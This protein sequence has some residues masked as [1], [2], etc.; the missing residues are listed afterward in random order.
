MTTPEP[1]D[2]ALPDGP[3][4]IVFHFRLPFAVPVDPDHA[5]AFVGKGYANASDAA[6]YPG[7]PFVRLQFTHVELDI[8]AAAPLIRPGFE[9]GLTVVLGHQGGETS[10]MP[11]LT[12]YDSDHPPTQTWVEAASPHAYLEGEDTGVDLG[13]TAFERS[14]RELNHLLRSLRTVH[15]ATGVR[16]INKEAL[17]FAA[18]ADFENEATGERTGVRQFFLLH[19]NIG[20]VAPPRLTAQDEAAV[21]RLMEDAN[22]GHPFVRFREWLDRAQDARNRRGDYEEAVVCLQTSVECLFD[23]LVKSTAVDAG[24]TA[25]AVAAR[26]S[27]WSE[28]FVTLLTTH[29]PHLLGGNWSRQG[30]ANPVGRYWHHVYLA[31]NRITHAGQRISYVEIEQASDAYAD[32]M[33]FVT[34]RVAARSKT[35]PRTALS[36]LGDS[37]LQARGAWGRSIREFAESLDQEPYPFWAPWDAVGRQQAKTDS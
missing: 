26:V 8:D 19:T 16:P 17:E 23:G 7:P 29:L 34:S 18:L 24:L 12:P 20:D 1:P 25:A 32:L 3:W 33:E 6:R 14:L 28:P 22:R 30:T 13:T 27:A 35:L 15:P 36:L 10:T 9:E 5:H 11:D 21:Y 37:E 31:R 2:G 4:Y